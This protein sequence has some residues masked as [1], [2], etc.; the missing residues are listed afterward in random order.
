M[1]RLL[2]LSLVAC[3]S[4]PVHRLADGCVAGAVTMTVAGPATYTCHQPFTS[5]ITLT[6]DTCEPLSVTGITVSGTVTDGSCTPPAAGS[7]AVN[8]TVAV[9][10]STAVF[11]YVGGD[12]CCFDTDCPAPFQCDE[13]YTW[14][15]DTSAGTITGSG[16]AHLS[17]D[18]CDVICPQ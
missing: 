16:S 4:E 12:F 3:G 11:N 2:L 17:L 13:S 15:A 1:R 14:T 5:T 7:A 10:A 8:K 18:S 6:N 9:G